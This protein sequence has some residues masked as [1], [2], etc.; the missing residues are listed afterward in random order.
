MSALVGRRS[1]RW[2]HCGG[3]LDLMMAMSLS[4]SPWEH[5]FGHI[6]QLDRCVDGLVAGASVSACFSCG[7]QGGAACHLPSTTM[8]PGGM[9]QR[10]T[11]DG[12]RMMDARRTV[13]S[14][15][16]MTASTTGLARSTH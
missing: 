3:L 16:I 4:L 13:A 12:R 6:H 7:D 5:H 15:I 11:G 1:P 2:R 9:V 8:S 10:D 14:S